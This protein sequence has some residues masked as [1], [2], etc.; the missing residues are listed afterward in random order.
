M[1]SARRTPH[2]CRALGR[3]L[4]S[5]CAR[6]GASRHAAVNLSSRLLHAGGPFESMGLGWPMADGGARGRCRAIR[7]PA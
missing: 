4:R 1:C 2:S 3:S 7:G 5:R 6:R